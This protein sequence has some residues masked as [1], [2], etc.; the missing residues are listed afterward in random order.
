VGTGLAADHRRAGAVPRPLA[1]YPAAEDKL[2][3]AL[4]A[5]GEAHIQAGQVGTGIAEIERAARR[6]PERGE[7][8]ARLAQLAT[9]AA[10]EDP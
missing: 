6:L 9:V 3:A 7:A 10:S 1:G 8:W 4:V 5:D 2:Y